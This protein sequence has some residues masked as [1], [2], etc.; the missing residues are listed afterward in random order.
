MRKSL[1]PTSVTSSPSRRE[2]PIAAYSLLVVCAALL[3]VYVLWLRRAVPADQ[4]L[5]GVL[6]GVLYG[7]LLPSYFLAIERRIVP[8]VRLRWAI[9]ALL[10]PPVGMLTVW[11]VAPGLAGGFGL[12]AFVSLL[13]GLAM[14]NLASAI[15]RRSDKSIHDADGQHIQ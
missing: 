7:H 10:F 14:L 5:R 6:I 8:R 2:G 9:F 4:T 12:G 13:L 1:K 15:S 11:M 3:V